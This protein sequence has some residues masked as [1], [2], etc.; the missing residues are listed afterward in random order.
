MDQVLLS[1]YPDHTGTSGGN[2][3]PSV[4]GLSLREG[5]RSTRSRSA[6]PPHQKEQLG[7]VGAF[8]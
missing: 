4:A 5:L 3:F 8:D 7:V 2:K 1:S 6:A